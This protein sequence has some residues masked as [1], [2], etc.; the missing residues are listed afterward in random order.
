MP[1]CFDRFN[2]AASVH[3]RYGT[4]QV[5]GM[6][7][8]WYSPRQMASW[9]RCPP[10]PKPPVAAAACLSKHCAILYSPCQ[11]LH[12]SVDNVLLV[13]TPSVVLPMMPTGKENLCLSLCLHA[14]LVPQ[15]SQFQQRASVV[16]F[17]QAITTCFAGPCHSS[18]CVMLV[19]A[20]CATFS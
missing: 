13:G 7:T 17:L 6:C 16:A 2:Q 20:C 5:T 19:I 1:S 3:G 4:M 8:G 18:S 15:L 14:C 11:P 10:R 12:V 9:W